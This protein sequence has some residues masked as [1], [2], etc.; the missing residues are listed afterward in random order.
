MKLKEFE[1][2]FKSLVQRTDFVPSDA[3]TKKF[4]MTALDNGDDSEL[5]DDSLS[6]AAGGLTL[7]EEKKHDNK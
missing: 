2:Y 7:H 3:E 1:Q 4:D 5:S 6:A